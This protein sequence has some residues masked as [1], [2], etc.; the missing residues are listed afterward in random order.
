VSDATNISVDEKYES[1]SYETPR[2]VEYGGVE[3]LTQLGGSV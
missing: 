3:E 1:E 2:L